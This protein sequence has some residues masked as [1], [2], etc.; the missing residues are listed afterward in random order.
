MAGGATVI[1][2]AIRRFIEL[3]DAPPKPASGALVLMWNSNGTLTT[4]DRV[5]VIIQCTDNGLW[6]QVGLHL[7]ADSGEPAF[8]FT[9]LSS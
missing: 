7:D 9:E 5:P 3:I 4:T 2:R 1:H 8:D 6:Y